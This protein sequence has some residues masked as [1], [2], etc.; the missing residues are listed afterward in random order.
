MLDADAQ[1]HA[2]LIRH[3]IRDWCY[4]ERVQHDRNS[5]AVSLR[6]WYAATRAHDIDDAHYPAVLSSWRRFIE[7]KLDPQREMDLPWACAPCGAHT[8]W[9]AGGSTGGP[10]VIRYRPA[11]ADRV[12][13]A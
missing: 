10:L 2:M 4:L 8:W 12:A 6:P 13:K 1:Q 11:G 9:N 7:G 5:N 3:R